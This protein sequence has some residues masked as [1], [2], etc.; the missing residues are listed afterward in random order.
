METIVSSDRSD[1]IISDRRATVMIGERINPTGKKKMADALRDREWDV[2]RKEAVA[3][4]AAGAGILDV[5]VAAPGLDETY[6]LPKAIEIIMTAV[7]VPL[8]IDINKTAAL[9]EAL[10]VCVGKPIVN[11]VSGE[12]KSLHEVLPLVKSHGAAVI[13]LTLDDDGIPREAEKRVAIAHRIVEH[14]VALGIPSED[15][16]VDCLTLALGPD[17]KAGMVT[18]QA[19]RQVKAELGVNQ[20]LGASNISFGLPDRLLINQTFVALAIEAGVTCPTVD[21]QRMAPTVLAT[22]LLLGRDRFCQRFIKDFRKR[23]EKH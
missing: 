18:L 13:A 3:Q 4:V 8:C 12:K 9:A 19:I 21:A 5:N 15:I 6:L 2:V 20:T 16:I 22:D 11:S 23:Q 7:D 14:A 17:D 10:K 1:V